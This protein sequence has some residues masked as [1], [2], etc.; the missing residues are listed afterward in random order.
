MIRAGLYI[1]RLLRLCDF[2]VVD[3]ACLWEVGAAS[4]VVE[5]FFG[6]FLLAYF[7]RPSC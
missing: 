7:C 4:F 5:N 3:P 6:A 2:E 1:P